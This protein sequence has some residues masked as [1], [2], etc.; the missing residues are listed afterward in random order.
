MRPAFLIVFSVGLLLLVTVPWSA[1]TSAPPVA[2]KAPLPAVVQGPLCVDPPNGLIGWWPGD[3]GNANDI[4]GSGNHGVLVGNTT[5]APGKVGNAFSFD[6][7]GD[8]VQLPIDSG[9]FAATDRFTIDAWAFPTRTSQFSFLQGILDNDVSNARGMGLS[10]FGGVGFNNPFRVHGFFHNTDL[11]PPGGAQ[12]GTGLLS[13]PNQWHH[14]AMTYDG[15]QLCTYQDGGIP[16]CVAANGEVKDNNVTFRIGHGQHS[17]PDVLRYFQ[18]L[19]DEVEIFDRALSGNEINSIFLAGA[20]GKCKQT[21]T[22]RTIGFWKNHQ[23][24]ASALLPQT[25]GSHL[26]AGFSSAS[27]IF[28]AASGRNAHNMLA[29]QLLA[30]KLNVANGVAASCTGGAIADADSILD[31][32]GYSGPNSTTAPKKGD[33][34]AVNA[35]KD[36]LDAFNNNGC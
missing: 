24:D 22:A 25:L 6:G 21:A 32:A 16:S 20:A 8:Y 28:R 18:G 31:A 33:K 7:D 36:V 30:S 5:F 10:V 34:A 26:V 11:I 12:F 23:P 1:A 14:Y 4:S 15:A 29:A 2:P 13:T 9:I 35:V 3:D 19:I 27:G 17:A